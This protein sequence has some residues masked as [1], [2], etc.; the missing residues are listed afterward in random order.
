[1][2]QNIQE[3]FVGLVIKKPYAVGSKSERQAVMLHCE[4]NKEWILR[5]IG[6]NAMS[7][8]RLEALVGKHIKTQGQLHRNILLIEENWEEI[9]VER[10]LTLPSERASYLIRK[11]LLAG[12]SY[13]VHQIEKVDEGQIPR[14]VDIRYSSADASKVEPIIAEMKKPSTW[15]NP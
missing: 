11:M 9:P 13:S 2:S 5:I 14:M 15:S 3:E 4:G 6:G 12:V 1:M 7:D 10:S 8:P